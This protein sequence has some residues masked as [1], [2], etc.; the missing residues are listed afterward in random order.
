MKEEEIAFRY[1][2]RIPTELKFTDSD[3][4]SILSNGL[5][6]A[7]H[8]VAALPVEKRKIELDMRMNNDKLLISIKNTYCG[9]PKIV[10][11]IPQTNALGHGFGTKSI[12]YVTEKLKGNCDFSVTEEYFILRIV[13]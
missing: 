11:G 10:D 8:A 9:K 13:L 6:N 5:E 7:V 2:V 3:L 4:S 1:S 12:R